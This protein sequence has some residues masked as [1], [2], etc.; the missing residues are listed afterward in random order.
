MLASTEEKWKKKAAQT[1]Q[2]HIIKK[3]PHQNKQ[4]TIHIFF[5]ADQASEL[6]VYFEN[7]K[8]YLKRNE[9]K[10]QHRKGFWKSQRFPHTTH[11]RKLTFFSSPKASLDRLSAYVMILEIAILNRAPTLNNIVM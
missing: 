5:F 11:T 6:Q 1:T 2:T 9:N 8:K 4:P 3:S 10:S 7:K